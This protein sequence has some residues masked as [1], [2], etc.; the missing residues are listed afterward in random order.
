M[1]DEAVS[2][3][4]RGAFAPDPPSLPH[5]AIANDASATAGTAI[6]RCNRTR[7]VARS[8]TAGLNHNVVV[9][10]AT[11]RSR[12]T[13][14]GF[15]RPVSPTEGEYRRCELDGLRSSQESA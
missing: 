5:A 15:G 3:T 9:H 6:R 1:P 10:R 11:V 2:S 7:F 8:P 4:N 14:T 13:T 12:R